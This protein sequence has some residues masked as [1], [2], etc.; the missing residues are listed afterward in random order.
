[1]RCDQLL[2]TDE[3]LYTSLRTLDNYSIKP[4]HLI[5]GHCFILTFQE[6]FKSFLIGI[7]FP[8]NSDHEQSR[9]QLVN[10][11]IGMVAT[12]FFNRDGLLW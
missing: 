10:I 6:R 11:I 4:V 2:V 5:R 3:S 8:A 7:R 9:Q 1:M 12:H